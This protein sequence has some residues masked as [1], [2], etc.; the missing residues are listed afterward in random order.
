MKS[1]Y[2]IPTVKLSLSYH[3][4]QRSPFKSR[5]LFHVILLI[6][7]SS[8]L[9]K[10]TTRKNNLKG[11]WLSHD[12]NM[13]LLHKGKMAGPSPEV[14]GSSPHRSNLGKLLPQLMW[15]KGE[16]PPERMGRGPGYCSFDTWGLTFCF[17]QAFT[18]SG[19][20]ITTPCSTFS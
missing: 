5:I 12:G 6:K 11:S 13:T 4:T 1:P 2:Y 17:R 7:N 16:L 9:S 8:K 10:F 20:Q 14:L 15:F 18:S 3:S 19:S